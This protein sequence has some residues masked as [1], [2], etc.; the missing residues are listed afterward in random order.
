MYIWLLP[1]IKMCNMKYYTMTKRFN[2]SNNMLGVIVIILTSMRVSYSHGWWFSLTEIQLQLVFM[3]LQNSPH[4]VRLSCCL[5]QMC[6]VFTRAHMD[7]FVW[8]KLLYIE[9]K[10][11]WER[12]LT[13]TNPR[14]I[15]APIGRISPSQIE[16]V[17]IAICFYIYNKYTS[18]IEKYYYICQFPF[19]VLLLVSRLQNSWLALIFVLPWVF[20]CKKL[21]L[22]SI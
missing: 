8:N 10:T 22:N 18:I 16:N 4:E 6:K 5:Q 7:I 20:R 21:Q 2:K 11:K 9:K 12:N 1:D 17:L 19:Q 14:Y 15:P 3:A 13:Y